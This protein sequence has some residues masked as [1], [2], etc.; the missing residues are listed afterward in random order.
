MRD[1]LIEQGV[2]NARSRDEAHKRA[3]QEVDD[4]TDYAEQAAP[5]RPES[6][7]DH[8]YVEDGE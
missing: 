8:V 7:L 6:A 2:L 3:A 5:P 1:K 4:A